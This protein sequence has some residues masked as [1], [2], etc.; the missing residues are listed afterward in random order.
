MSSSE[1]PLDSLDSDTTVVRKVARMNARGKLALP[2]RGSRGSSSSVRRKDKKSPREYVS[3]AQHILQLNFEKDATARR[4]AERREA[5]E[6]SSDDE[7]VDGVRRDRFGNP[8][9]YFL[10][11]WDKPPRN[12]SMTEKEENE[13]L[14]QV[15]EASQFTYPEL[16]LFLKGSDPLFHGCISDFQISTR[17]MD[18]LATGDPELM[19][20]FTDGASVMAGNP[21]LRSAFETLQRAIHFQMFGYTTTRILPGTSQWSYM[22]SLQLMC[23]A[24]SRVHAALIGETAAVS[25]ERKTRTALKQFVPRDTAAWLDDPTFF[26]GEAGSTRLPGETTPSTAASPGDTSSPHPTRTPASPRRPSSIPGTEFGGPRAE[27]VPISTP[28]TPIPQQ[29]PQ[30]IPIQIL[31]QPPA[32]Q[33]GFTPLAVPPTSSTGFPLTLPQKPFPQSRYATSFRS[34]GRRR[35][36]LEQ[37]ASAFTPRSQSASRP[38][39]PPQSGSRSPGARPVWPARSEPQY[40]RAD[41][42][43]RPRSTVMGRGRRF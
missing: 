6:V 22:R 23:H 12:I 25:E 17:E 28:P 36:F 29:T 14:P 7:P 41:D 32:T 19:E 5:L 27:P 1:S 13:V 11:K 24:L 42:N 33:P 9:K 10:S 18:A 40:R 43:D 20:P 15:E 39:L 34:P 31:L 2:L 26:R 3:K 35:R 37:K 30:Q 16:F 21:E 38:G 4:L 8:K